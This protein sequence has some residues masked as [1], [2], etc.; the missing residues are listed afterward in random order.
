[1]A[2]AAHPPPWGVVE[3]PPNLALLGG[4][5]P[6]WMLRNDEMGQTLVLVMQ[7]KRNESDVDSATTIN[8][9]SRNGTRLP[10]AFIV[11]KSIEAVIGVEAARAMQSIRE[12]RGLRYLLRTNSHTTYQ[13]IQ[14]LD[15]LCDGTKVEVFPHPTMNTIQGIVFEPDTIDL[16][17]QTILEFLSSQG[18]KGVR[19]I[20]K[21]VGRGRQN[22]PLL[23]L[24]FHGTKLPEDVYFGL[25]KV[26]TRKYYPTPMLCFNCGCFGHTK[27]ACSNDKICLHC[28]Q[29]HEMVDDIPCSND[30]HC[31]NCQGCHSAFSKTCPI[32]VEEDKIMRYRVDQ[33]ISLGEARKIFKAQKEQRTYA[34]VVQQ[35]LI[36]QSSEKDQLIQ[37]LREQLDAVK[38]ELESLKKQLQ[39]Q[40]TDEH[41]L[42][43]T[44]SKRKKSDEKMITSEQNTKAS[45]TTASSSFNETHEHQH[46]TRQSRKDLG[47]T[48]KENKKQKDISKMIDCSSPDRNRSRS[49][50]R[51]GVELR[52]KDK[53]LN[54]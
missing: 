3:E 43:S 1:M 27:K 37:A 16:D 49:N 6:N 42:P 22:T 41:M 51:N 14:Q 46:N 28:S 26:P 20:T 8:E 47:N 29:I 2:V 11:G 17:E 44:S 34:S 35:R 25:L 33:N 13:K 54:K 39:K 15:T 9:I 52:Q 36:E 24:T 38:A 4:N 10:H 5:Q 18:V 19:R 23:I 30:A 45:T 40:A 48:S 50:R 32:Y 53:K 7:V 21:Q 31:K 12:A